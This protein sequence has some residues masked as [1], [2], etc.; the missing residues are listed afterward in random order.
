MALPL[1]VGDQVLG[2]LDVQSKEPGAFAQEDIATLQLLADQVAVAIE[3]ARL[4]SESQTSLE[5]MRRSYGELSRE[6]WAKMLHDRPEFGVLANHF[7]IL[8][9]PSGA[10]AP[11]MLQAAQ[12]GEMI[13][14]GDGTVA[15]PIKDREHILGTLRLRKPGGYPWSKEEISL[16]E[17]LAQQLYLALENARLYRETQRRAER[18]RLAGDI[19]AKMRRSNDPQEILQ[20]AVHELRQALNLH[21]VGP[22]PKPVLTTPETGLDGGS[23]TPNQPEE[24]QL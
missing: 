7:D 2:A 8:Y 21:Q 12:S 24:G 5:A 17:T 22:S 1:V 16:A 9:T 11:E 20:T 23:S 13:S 19:T 15:I 4:F 3:N 6:A 10:W 14:T 18:E